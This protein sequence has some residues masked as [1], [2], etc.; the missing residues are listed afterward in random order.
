MDANRALGLK[1]PVIRDEGFKLGKAFG[2]RGT[3]AAVLV[4]AEGRIASTVGVGAR[5]VLALAGALSPIPRRG[6]P[7]DS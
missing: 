3:P 7:A 4:D 5:D 2:A 6:A 1:S